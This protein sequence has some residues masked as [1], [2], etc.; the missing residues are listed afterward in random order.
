MVLPPPL[1]KAGLC[2]TGTMAKITNIYLETISNHSDQEVV[3]WLNDHLKRIAK[4][5]QDDPLI[6]LGTQEALLAEMMPVL[7]LLDKRMNQDSD[8]P[9]VA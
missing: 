9:V 6:R 7:D 3:A 4:I 5:K 2:Y 8:E 1:I